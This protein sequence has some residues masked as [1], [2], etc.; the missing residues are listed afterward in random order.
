[1]DD[2]SSDGVLNLTNGV[3]ISHRGYPSTSYAPSIQTRL[4]L[5][6][7][8]LQLTSLVIWRFLSFDV[9]DLYYEADDET[10]PP[11]WYIDTDCRYSDNLYMRGRRYCNYLT[12]QPVI[13]L[14]F[15]SS[16]STG[17]TSLIQFRTNSDAEVGSGFSLD[18]TGNVD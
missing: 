9:S 14:P 13:N 6:T 7:Q 3:I 2:N 12:R 8:N 11:G 10:F 18:Y 1:M 17:E 15:T 16:V 4:T 5:P